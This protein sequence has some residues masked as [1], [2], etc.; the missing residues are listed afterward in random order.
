MN[1]LLPLS[2]FSLL[3]CLSSCT[4]PAP[5]QKPV[6]SGSSLPNI[7]LLYADDLG[8]GDVSSYGATAIAT[9][10]IDRIATEGIRFTNAHASSATCTP[11]RYSLLT[12]RY[13]WRQRGTGVAPGDAALIIDTATTTL[14]D[15]LQRAGYAT[16]VV[17]KWH[18]GLG[19][20]GGPDWNGEIGPGPLDLGFD[21]AF[22]IPATGDRVPCVYVEGRRVVDLDPADPIAV[23]YREPVGN[24]PT[25]K[26]NPELLKVHPSHGHDQTIVNGISRIGYMTGGASAL[27]KDEDMADV[28]VGRAR[29]FMSENQDQP[30]FLYLATHDIH[31][32][33]VPHPRFAGKSGMGPRGDAILQL[34]WTVGAVLN[35]LDSLKLAENTLVLFTSDNGPVLDDG[36][37][38][39]ARELVGKHR[40]AGP[41]RG[42]KYSLYNAGTR[43]PMVLRWPRR[44][45]PG[46][47]SEA[48]LGQVDL[49]ASFA[50]LCGQSPGDGVGDDS[51]DV[52]PA[53]LGDNGTGRSELVV[54]AIQGGLAIIAD[55]WKYIPPHDGPAM[56]PWGPVIETGFQTQGQLYE[57]T[58][59][60]GERNNRAKSYP[61]KV[62][63][64][65]TRMAAIKR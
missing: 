50:T 46:Q 36:Y 29:R 57:L 2:A 16:S 17:G 32:P 7:V 53:V 47:V 28:L 54:E 42:G 62:R 61:D 43:V 41:L 64:L 9:P 12:G 44:V 14:P 13:A 49:L 4:D 52:L 27:W 30:F 37:V 10:H 40:P 25:G 33:R 35:I 15:I 20:S 65:E 45:E 31:V 5:D 11:S 6:R 58:A 59:D 48:L 22:L 24:W 18:L 1:Y 3:L 21:E 38:D 26:A 39:Q 19:G 55:G 63:D 51:Q 34:D 60:P 23:S 56:V 8:Y